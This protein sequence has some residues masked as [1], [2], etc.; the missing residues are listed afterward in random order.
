MVGRMLSINVTMGQNGSQT[1]Q[2]LQN[3]YPNQG[4]HEELIEQPQ[5]DEQDYSQ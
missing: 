2:N 3:E 4:Q 5:E 1:F